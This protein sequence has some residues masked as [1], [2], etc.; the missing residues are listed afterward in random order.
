MSN[1]TELLA[2]MNRADAR[3]GGSRGT[4]ENRRKTI[5]KFVRYVKER[6]Y[7]HLRD[8][9]E[10]RGCYAREYI[11]WRLASGADKRTL[12]NEMAHIR[13]LWRAC[14]MSAIADSKDLTN[15][16]LGIGGAPRYG[17]KVAISNER[18]DACC[19]IAVE[20]GRFGI[21]LL[22]R[23]QRALGLR[24]SEAI[25][26]D[27]DTLQGW[28]RDLETR[29]THVCVIRGTKGG[30]P[31][32]VEIEDPVSLLNLIVD[33]ITLASEQNGYLILRKDGKSAG[34]LKQARSIYRSWCYHHGL[35]S[36]SLR[37]AWTQHHYRT[38]AAQGLSVKAILRR[39]ALSLGHGDDRGHYVKSHYLI[40][41][42]L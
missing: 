18:L 35:Q 7:T 34:G 21:A 39:L 33:A 36:H 17:K 10:V 42:T 12:Q 31:R 14:G 19:R 26:S 15:K 30:R 9:R 22:L 4:H 5:H 41:M 16:K 24:S 8:M 27:L 28:K 2:S 13:M 3:L 20:S 40:G 6:G 29:A 23:L 1:K 32:W 38:L 25:C 37:Y 11:S